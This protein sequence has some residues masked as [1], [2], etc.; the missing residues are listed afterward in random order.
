MDYQNQSMGKTMKDQTLEATVSTI[1]SKTTYAGAGTSVVGWFAS[2]EF[3]VIGGLVIGFAGLIV[4]WYYKHKRDKREQEE[5]EI[6]MN[7]LQ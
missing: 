5:H 7:L 2:N 4:N 6:K 3:A 1:A